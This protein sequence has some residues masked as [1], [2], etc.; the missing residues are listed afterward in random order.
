ML[1]LPWRLSARKRPNKKKGRGG[2]RNPLIKLDSAKEMQGFH[3][4]F[5]VPDLGF[6]APGLDFVPVDLEILH[7]AGR[8]APDVSVPEKRANSHRFHRHFRL[9]ILASA[10]GAR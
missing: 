10:R 9:M 4:D 3:L 7:R 1:A 6:V 2:R 5:V 8:P